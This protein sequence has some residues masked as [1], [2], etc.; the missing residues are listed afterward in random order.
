MSDGWG[1]MIRAAIAQTLQALDLNRAALA[2]L[3]SVSPKTLHR[4]E[5][6]EGQPDS[7]SYAAAMVLLQAIYD[8]ISRYPA[9]I[10]S[11]RALAHISVQRDG[12]PHFIDRCIAAYL[13]ADQKG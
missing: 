13:A 11:L 7:G 12:L 1:P 5:H 9:S 3:L 6:G 10:A 8:R 4:W 2:K